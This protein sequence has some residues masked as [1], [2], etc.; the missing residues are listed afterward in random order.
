MNA[1]FSRSA[2]PAGA[3]RCSRRWPSPRTA[4]A[5]PRVPR[6]RDQRSIS[7]ASRDRGG[8]RRRRGVHTGVRRGVGRGACRGRGEIS[9][10]AVS[11]KKKKKEERRSGIEFR[12]ALVE[13][14]MKRVLHGKGLKIAGT[15]ILRY[16]GL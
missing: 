10:G 14:K 9:V 12:L 6:A 15:K 1:Q 16:A 8:N 2:R 11:F 13:A 4:A 5:P 7:A 3:T